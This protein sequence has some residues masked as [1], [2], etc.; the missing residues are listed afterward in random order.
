M[1]RK[2][3]KLLCGGE[4]FH[5]P[6][7][8]LVDTGLFGDNPQLLKEE[9]YDVKTCASPSIFNSFM[10][11]LEGS[12][13]SIT[14]ENYKDL[15]NLSAE[16]G[17]DFLEEALSSFSSENPEVVSYADEETRQLL[18][19]L[20]KD[21]HR[22]EKE[23]ESM[24]TLQASAEERIK[25]LSSLVTSLSQELKTSLEN[26]VEKGQVSEL[27]KQ[28]LALGETNE[29][30]L[31]MLKEMGEVLKTQRYCSRD[32]SQG[33]ALQNVYK[34]KTC[35][36]TVEN[37]K[38]LCERCAITCHAGHNVSLVG[39][40]RWDC[41]CDNC[42][43]RLPKPENPS[44]CS[45]K[46]TG[47]TAQTAHVWHCETCNMTSKLGLCVCDACKRTCHAD[48]KVVDGGIIDFFCDCGA[49]GYCTC[50][51][52]HGTKQ[53]T[54][55]NTGK[56]IIGQPSFKCQTC[57]VSGICAACIEQCHKSHNTKPTGFESFVCSCG[58][59]KCDC[60]IKD[61]TMEE[62][63]NPNNLMCTFAATGKKMGRQPTFRCLTCGM[64]GN[65]VCCESCANICHSGHLV[66]PLG[67]IQSYC[68]CGAGEFC[69]CVLIENLKK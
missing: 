35:D 17:T 9:S 24:K 40:M 15:K 26:N 45:F 43:S 52:P 46:T 66:M 56:R 5:V 3:H 57:R 68:D 10:D 65:T 13:I 51:L 48:H 23:L 29:L 54:L 36:M 67:V 4:E 25:T 22:Q 41:R 62:E 12:D 64:K 8:I 38:G 21:V 50:K 39:K 34:C 49:G 19:E 42:C 2:T 44:E 6:R 69:K 32:T 14:Q 58:S 60:Q 31:V 33:L 1:I 20:V 47:T 28:V 30:V 18:H 59:G 61:P 55:K 27:N 63:L 7:A 11:A 53:C 16:F 37:K